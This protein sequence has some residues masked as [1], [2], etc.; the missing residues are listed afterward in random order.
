MVREIKNAKSFEEI[1]FYP[2][3]YNETPPPE[4]VISKD[5]DSDFRIGQIS[6]FRT[7][8]NNEIL[9]REKI[10]KSFKNFDWI[11]FAAEI[12]FVAVEIGISIAGIVCPE[13]SV[14]TSS[15]CVIITTVST[16]MRGIFKKIMSK[17]EKHNAMLYLAKSKLAIVKDKY[18]IAMKD[19][20][21][22]HQEFLKIVD[23]Y[24]KYEAIRQDTLDKY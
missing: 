23:E 21:I 1:R 12:L 14:T 5:V 24:G 13:F 18:D 8:L 3:E 2:L 17:L 9:K 7:Y 10:I 19:G 4:I 22:D 6:R 16:S 15:A 20:Q 11:C